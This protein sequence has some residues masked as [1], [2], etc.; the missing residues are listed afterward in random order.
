MNPVIFYVDDQEENLA[1]FKMT[2]PPEWDVYT[3]NHPTAAVREL[4]QKKPW[5]ILSDQ[6]MPSM[7]GCEFL[8]ICKDIFPSAIRIIV[9]GYSDE[10]QIIASLRKAQITDLIKKPWDNNELIT[11]IL[12][13]ISTYQHIIKSEELSEALRQN[14][15]VLKENH[16]YVSQLVHELSLSKDREDKVKKEFEKWVPDFIVDAVVKGAPVASINRDI[17]GIIFD[18]KSSRDLFEA[19]FKG[20]PIRNHIIQIFTE[21]V[22]RNNGHRESVSGDSS[23]GHFGVMKQ[24]AHPADAAFSAAREFKASV[25]LVSQLSNTKLDIGVG[26]NFATSSP[27]HI[28]TAHFQTD[29]GLSA[30]RSFDTSSYDT[31]LL[32]RIEKIVHVLP[33]VSIVMTDSF[34]KKIDCGDEYMVDLGMCN[35]EGVNEP[36]HLHVLPSKYA[37]AEQIEALKRSLVTRHLKAV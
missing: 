4:Y 28:H 25:E 20:S 17:A 27:I 1:V 33:G 37:K 3:F 24:H 19:K 31:D 29:N 30:Q 18:I 36:I 12:H 9:T 16:Q 15:K 13:G 10:S 11:R 21:A 26:L 22:C 14:Q 2:C 5:V 23:Y 8:E 35:I 6:K 32:H 7:T 34:F